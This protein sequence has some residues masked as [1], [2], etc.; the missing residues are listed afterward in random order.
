VNEL[1]EE[2]QNKQ[3]IEKRELW[4]ERFEKFETSGKA[5]R[6]FCLENDISE[7]QF[8]FWRLRLRQDGKQN[9]ARQ[10]SPKQ[11]SNGFVPLV[12]SSKMDNGQLFDIL[13]PGKAVIKVGNNTDLKLVS[14]LLK[15]LEEI[16]C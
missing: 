11:T 7:R 9:K 8:Y 13:L 12:V 5:I 10:E 4:K 2:A 14:L 15:N 1:K 3:E 16:K 6:Q